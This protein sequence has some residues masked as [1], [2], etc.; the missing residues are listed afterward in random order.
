MESAMIIEK[1]SSVDQGY[2]SRRYAESLYHVGSPLKLDESGAWVIE[3]S[4]PDS[5]DT[6]VVGCYPL[7]A[8][9]EWDLLAEDIAKLEDHVVSFTMVTDP[10]GDF[11]EQSLG[12]VFP[13]LCKPFKRHHLVDLQSDF[14]TSIASNHA[15]NAKKAARV[16]NFVREEQPLSILDD[17]ISMYDNL[18]ERH[19]IKGVAA[20][21]REAFALQLDTPGI[22]VYSAL[23][24]G[25]R[26]GMVLFYVMN[27]SVYY[28]LGA[29]LPAG[30]ENK[31][32]FGIFRSALDDFKREGYHFLNFGGGAGLIEDEEDGLTRFKRGWANE[33][34]TAYLCGAILNHN[35]YS[36][37]TNALAGGSAT[38][39]F[40]PAYRSKL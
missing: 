28:H 20:F 7:M 22:I 34:R 27:N 1:P 18:V 24:A 36:D 38:T 2:L 15:R 5:R 16:L 40:F 31:A 17:W 26:V 39:S 35:A 6:D 11:E 37:L 8:C 13:S 23:Q 4:I 32:S 29:Y 12:Q 3:R 19:A 10:L 21:S 25:V 9:K 33:Q 30:Y 14:E